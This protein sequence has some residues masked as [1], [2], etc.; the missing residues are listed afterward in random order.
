AYAGPSDRS[1]AVA[2]DQQRLDLAVNVKRSRC[3]HAPILGDSQPGHHPTDLGRP[4]PATGRRASRRSAAHSHERCWQHTVITGGEHDP[5]LLPGCP[6]FAGLIM[7][8]TRPVSGRPQAEAPAT[9]SRVE[10]VL[11]Q[12]LARL[13]RSVGFDAARALAYDP[14][15]LIPVSFTGTGSLLD[16]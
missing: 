9:P 16:W 5:R 10:E 13:G 2:V 11:A 8:E 6:G 15:V 7:L 3:A 4:R 1:G 14:D 12:A